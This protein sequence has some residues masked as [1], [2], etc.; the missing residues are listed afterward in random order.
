[1][2]VQ[3]L[4]IRLSQ[5]PSNSSVVRSDHERCRGVSCTCLPRWVASPK[6]FDI[7]IASGVAWSLHSMLVF[8]SALWHHGLQVRRGIAPSIASTLSK[9][10]GT[11]PL[12]TDPL[13]SMDTFDPSRRKAL[14]NDTKLNCLASLSVIHTVNVT[15]Y[16]TP[17]CTTNAMT[18][19]S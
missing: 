7:E 6:R 8:L 5:R 16:L 2:P 12:G 19:P 9:I 17:L 15:S 14:C 13:P 4:S 3:E 1:M 10:D 18:C 11:M